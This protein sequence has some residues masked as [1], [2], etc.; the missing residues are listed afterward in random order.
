VLNICL[1]EDPGSL[2]RYEGRNSLAKQS[3]FSALYDVDALFESLPSYAN[4]QAARQALDVKPGM[5]M[6]DSSGEVTVLKEGSQIHPVIEGA[7]G[8]PTAW[9]ASAP[10]QMMQVKVEYNI[11]PGLLWSDGSPVTS[12]DFLLAYE[13]ANELRNPQD[14]WLLDRTAGL[15]ALDE[16][17][18][19]WTGV[20]GF[21]PVDLSE[22]VFPLCL[23]A[24]FSGMT[25]VE[26][27]T[28][29]KQAIRQS[30]GGISIVDRTP[31]SAISW[32]QPV[33]QPQTAM[34]RW[35]CWLSPTCSRRSASWKAVG[36]MFWTPA[37]TWK[38]KAGMC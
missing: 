2:F 11:T 8:E 20:P 29:G 26:I 25:P 13:V 5:N 32:T 23:P 31:G 16:T 35:S 15:E 34:T 21:V 3:V 6:L 10:L 17:T 28:P 27:G 33:L 30:A 14:L 7:L 37:T 12:A 4:N 1:A 22:L 24:Q 9:S 36:V 19:T 38:G 18:L